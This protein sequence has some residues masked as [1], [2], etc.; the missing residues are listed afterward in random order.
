[1]LGAKP[2]KLCNPLDARFGL[3]G[4]ARL[5]PVERIKPAPGM[6]FYIAKRLVLARESI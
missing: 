1:M 3:T 5:D 4:L 6:G 2:V